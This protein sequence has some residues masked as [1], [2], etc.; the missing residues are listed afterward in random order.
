MPQL[1]FFI[2][3]H[4]VIETIICLFFL[5]LV[6]YN[7]GFIRIYKALKTRRLLLNQLSQI[8][9]G[10]KEVTLEDSFEDIT[11]AL[12]EQRNGKKNAE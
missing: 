3:P 11:K 4:I 8:N 10:T 5:F 7:D 9:E 1:D 2:Y 6:I 12:I